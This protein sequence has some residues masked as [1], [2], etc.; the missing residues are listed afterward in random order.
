MHV[1]YVKNG[2]IYLCDFYHKKKC[3]LCDY[4]WLGEMLEYNTPGF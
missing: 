4:P 1:F 2:T 3:K